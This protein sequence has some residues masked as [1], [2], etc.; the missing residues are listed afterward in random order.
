MHG[1]AGMRPPWRGAVF[2]RDG[3]ALG[4]PASRGWLPLPPSRKARGRS[5][6]RRIPSSLAAP[7]CRGA[8]AFRRSVVAISVPGAVLPGADPGGFRL[9]PI[10]RAFARLRRRRVQPRRAVPR[11][12]DGRRPGASRV[13]GYEPRP[14]APPLPPFQQRPAGT[15]LGGEGRRN[16]SLVAEDVKR[17]KNG[18]PVSALGLNRIWLLATQTS[19]NDPE[20]T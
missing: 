9:N 4:C 16:I 11:S 20:L 8:G 1:I 14:R 12:G 7:H 15:P 17:P 6:A 2:V 19:A 10:R 5:A 18:R 3:M 13:R